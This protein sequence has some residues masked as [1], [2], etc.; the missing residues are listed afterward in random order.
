[1]YV[2]VGFILKVILASSVAGIYV[3]T[4]S[5]NGPGFQNV[6]LGDV[7][8]FIVVFVIIYSIMTAIGVFEYG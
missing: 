3:S 2:S 6:K 7:I 1:M 8:S 4:T 5:T